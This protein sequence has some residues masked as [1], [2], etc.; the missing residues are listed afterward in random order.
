M[1]GYRSNEIPCLLI[2]STHALTP[3]SN[4]SDVQRRCLALAALRWQ[5]TA[6]Y[7][8]V[9]KS[10]CVCVCACACACACV[11]VCAHVWLVVSNSCKRLRLAGSRNGRHPFW[12]FLRAK[13]FHL[14]KPLQRRTCPIA[15]WTVWIIKTSSSQEQGFWNGW[16]CIFTV[17]FFF[18]AFSGRRRDPMLRLCK[19]SEKSGL[20]SSVRLKAWCRSLVF[21]SC[22]ALVV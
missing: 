7:V 1:L 21:S 20:C 10:L 6:V 22:L 4:V 2:Y 14:R 16:A 9:S 17:F 8:C 12:A 3:K 19:C 11:C 18:T 13:H 15:V 5:L